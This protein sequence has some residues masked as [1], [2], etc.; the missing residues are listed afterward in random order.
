M[1]TPDDKLIT[2]AEELRAAIE[3]LST[4]SAIGFDSETT[5]LDPY[6]GR[7]RL[8]QL[9]APDQVYIFDLDRF[10]NGDVKRAAA[11]EP[12]RRLLAAERPV[13]IAHN[14]LTG[15]M[16][17]SMADGTK[18]LLGE[19]VRNKTRAK[20]L[21]LDE[22]TGGLVVGEIVDWIDA[23]ISPWENWLRIRM[24]GKGRL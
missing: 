21:C 24:R 4:Q 3:R 6:S 8:V 12:L 5:S 13:K 18:V 22:K 19:L 2:T 20:V 11:L 9:A 10:A 1:N 16:Q 17:V 14:C 23:G 15:D 7:M